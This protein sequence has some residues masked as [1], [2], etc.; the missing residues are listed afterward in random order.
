[1]DA[2]LRC[3][4]EMQWISAFGAGGAIDEHKGEV[5]GA[6]INSEKQWRNAVENARGLQSS[7]AKAR[8]WWR[9][10]TAKGRGKE[11]LRWRGGC[12]GG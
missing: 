8:F 4:G 10:S 3:N 7:N 12:N 2:W 5:L 11:H 9:I 6:N 1:M